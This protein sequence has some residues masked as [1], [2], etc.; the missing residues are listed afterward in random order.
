[1]E[2]EEAT[3]GT[4][5]ASRPDHR[6]QAQLR[7][8][9]TFPAYTTT[10]TDS[11]VTLWYCGSRAAE[12]LT[13]QATADGVT[14]HGDAAVARRV[15]HTAARPLLAIADLP[16]HPAA[17]RLLYRRYAGIRPV[18]F[19]AAFEGVAWT[20]L[21]QQ[22]TMGFA[23]RLKGRLARDY[24]PEV[25]GPGGSAW[26]FPGPGDFARASVEELR[27]L[28]L[29][30]QKAETLVTIARAIDC[31]Q[32]DPEQ[33]FREPTAVAVDN[34]RRFRGVGRWTAE[35][36]LLRVAGHADLLPAG[37]AG[38]QR[39][40]A[41]L[42]G[43]PGR[44]DERTLQEAGVAWTGWRSDFAFYLWLDNRAAREGTASAVSPAG[45]ASIS[46]TWEGR[47]PLP[48]S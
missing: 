28:Q 26:V 2:A 32:W 14:V 18:L 4:H 39:A 16:A 35:Y 36:I 29:S 5:L 45:A 1:M 8:L 20:I 11:Q 24:G 10:G 3:G 23:A 27:R 13:L 38:L 47:G 6:L 42:N 7:F 43:L 46:S 44:S 37:D 33:A 21:G 40:W 31:G 17:H 48:C 25:S 41:R 19:A 34:L 15:L 12:H 9:R 30:R 22:I